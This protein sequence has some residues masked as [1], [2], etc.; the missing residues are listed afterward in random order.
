MH[1]RHAKT[2]V[3]YYII[4]GKGKEHHGNRYHLSKNQLLLYIN[5]ISSHFCA[6]EFSWLETNEP[7][8]LKKPL[9]K[10]NVVNITKY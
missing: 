2:S 5:V 6:S 1:D 10:Q 4:T 8:M 7:Y 9:Y 3:L